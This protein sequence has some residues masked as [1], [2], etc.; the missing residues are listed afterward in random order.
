MRHPNPPRHAPLL[1]LLPIVMLMIGGCEF[2]SFVTPRQQTFDVKAQYRGLE[3]QSV[4]VL[5]AAD[6]Y[7]LFR[8]PKAP[9]YTAKA[10]S[11]AI[12]GTVPGARLVD[13]KRITRF[14]K[15]NPWWATMQYSHIAEQLGADRLIIIDLA[16]YRTR[17]PGNAYIWRGVMSGN[18]AVVEADSPDPDEI[19]FTADIAVQFPEEGA[20]GVL[21]ESDETMQLGMLKL[22]SRDVSR[23]FHDHQITM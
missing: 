19:V 12:Q 4:A 1:I 15:E 7:T 13:P 8:F 18:V 5:V 10:V 9:Q 16:E 6:E 23:L 22:F 14:Q 3:D 17:E 20:V 21:D 2:S 11:G